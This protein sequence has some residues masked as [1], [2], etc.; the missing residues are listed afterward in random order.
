MASP[1]DLKRAKAGD[2][3]L[4]GANLRGAD[5]TDADVAEADLSVAMIWMPD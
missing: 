2:K 3:N 5:L 1:K 4:R